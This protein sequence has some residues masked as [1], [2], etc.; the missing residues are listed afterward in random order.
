MMPNRVAALLRQ[1]SAAPLQLRFGVVTSASPL[2]VQI[3]SASSG[4]PA[5]ALTS[6]AT[7]VVNDVVAVLVQGADRVV[8]GTVV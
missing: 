5:R 8:I 2:E 6:Y 7:P 3:G 4:Q 1:P